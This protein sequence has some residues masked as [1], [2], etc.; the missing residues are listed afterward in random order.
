[1]A[2]RQENARDD[3]AGRITRREQRKQRARRDKRRSIWFFLGMMGLVGW[4]VAVPSVIGVYL[5]YLADK[6]WPT[7]FSWTLTGLVL[8]VT[9]GS[10]SAWYWV[11]KESEKSD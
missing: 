6:T 5:G 7:E 11:K 8:G 10:L 9:A 2:E 3:F 1:V 4:S